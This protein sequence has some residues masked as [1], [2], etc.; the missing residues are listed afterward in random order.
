MRAPDGTEHRLAGS[1]RE[2]DPPARLVFTHAWI[3]DDG[4]PGP[5]TLVTVD[6]RGGR[7]RHADAFHPDRFRNALRRATATAA[8]GSESFERLE[9]H[10]ASAA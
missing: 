9:A 3:D 4:R 8:A 6:V 2:I 1:Y 5:E 10:L 7:G